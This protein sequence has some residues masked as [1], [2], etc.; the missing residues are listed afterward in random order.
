MIFYKSNLKIEVG[1]M[2]LIHYYFSRIRLM[3][4]SLSKNQSQWFSEKV[5]NAQHWFMLPYWAQHVPM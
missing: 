5:R 4:E 3:L 2:K 1:I